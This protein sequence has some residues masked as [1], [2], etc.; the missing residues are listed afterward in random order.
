MP[1]LGD[2][3]LDLNCRLILPF[4]VTELGSTPAE[5]FSASKITSVSFGMALGWRFE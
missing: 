1:R 5:Y 4:G 3:H 2:A